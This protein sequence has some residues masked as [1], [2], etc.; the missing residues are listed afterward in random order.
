MTLF[1]FI[2]S[3][4][5]Q[6]YEVSNLFK[7]KKFP[8]L[9]QEWNIWRF[10]WR[11]IF[12]AKNAEFDERCLIWSALSRTRM[13]TTQRVKFSQVFWPSRLKRSNVKVFRALISTF[14]VKMQDIEFMS[15]KV[16][17]MAYRRTLWRLIYG[18]SEGSNDMP[19][20][21]RIGICR[22]WCET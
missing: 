18:V 17:Y 1:G 15:T 22:K 12:P 14:S 11:N 8:L 7:F 16:W 6:R 5:I 13:Q 4:D 3:R 2:R 10:S 19:Q 9:F 20:N 21:L